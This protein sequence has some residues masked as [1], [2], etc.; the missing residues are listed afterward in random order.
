MTSIIPLVTICSTTHN[1]E[2]YIGQ[3][4]D[5][6]LMQKTTFPVEII[7]SDNCSNDHT[8]QII[9]EYMERYPGKITLIT[10]DTNTGMMSNFF[11]VLEAAN[12]KYIANCD[13]D[14]YWT[15]EFK[16][17]KQADFL[18]ANPN[19][20]SVYTNSIIKDES[21]REEKVA[22]LHTWDVADTEALLDHNDFIN[23]NLQLSPGHISTFFFRNFLINK[24]PDWLYG[25]YLNDFP[26]YIL[27]SKFGLAKFIDETATVYRVHSLGV[28]SHNF[29]YV[30][31]YMDR[32]YVYKN[33]DAHFHSKYAKKIKP[34][35]S[36]HY[37]N[38][39]KYHYRQKDVG[40]ALL[41]L[42]NALYYGKGRVSKIS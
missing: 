18:E 29:S 24:Y 21:T 39:A 31:T 12:G 41:A 2:K 26:L 34:L 35:I 16:I 4:I 28:S 13:G 3:A 22:K 33:L 14:D 38:I 27:V 15:D 10:S 25:C 37:Y 17:Q 40:H 1:R 23:D 11:K 8:V 7:I 9:E 42:A 5:S 19:F 6:W 36:R 20:S 30:D 32:I